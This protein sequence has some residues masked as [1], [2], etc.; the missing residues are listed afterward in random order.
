MIW[1]RKSGYFLKATEKL[2][3]NFEMQAPC[4]NCDIVNGYEKSLYFAT[5]VENQLNNVI[6]YD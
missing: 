1:T 2:K 4:L 3:K 6:C 5:E